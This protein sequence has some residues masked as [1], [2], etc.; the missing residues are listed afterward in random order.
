MN[1]QPGFII[2]DAI[3]TVRILYLCQVLNVDYDNRVQDECI[4]LG[5]LW[6]ED[7]TF[8]GRIF[9]SGTHPVLGYHSLHLQLDVRI[10]EQYLVDGLVEQL[11]GIFV[12]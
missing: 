8:G 7:S 11:S 2:L 12:T 6:K 4:V 3:P 10:G 1:L 5:D 9:V